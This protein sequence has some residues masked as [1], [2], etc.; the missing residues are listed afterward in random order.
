MAAKGNPAG[1]LVLAVLLGGGAWFFFTR[2]TAHDAEASMK[3][4]HNQVTS[5]AVSQYEIAK[6]SGG[7]MDACVR[8]GITAESFLQAQDE[9]S[10]QKWK[11]A[12][13]ADCAAAGIQK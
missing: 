9:A 11:A 4:I 13:K 1:V 7:P 5:D 10:Y 2:K 6:R 12:E 8:A 3:N